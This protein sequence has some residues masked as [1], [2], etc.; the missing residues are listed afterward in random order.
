M[1]PFSDFYSLKVAYGICKAGYL[2]EKVSL[3]DTLMDEARQAGRDSRA[4]L[5][6][7]ISF[8]IGVDDTPIVRTRKTY[9]EVMEALDRRIYGMKEIKERIA[10][11]ILA[12]QYAGVN[13][14]AM[15]LVG[16][17]GVGKTSIA[18][19]VAEV[20]ECEVTYVDCSGVDAVGM[21]GLTKSYC[22]AQPS[23]I[24][25]ALQE[26]GRLDTVL[27]IDELDKLSTGDGHGDPFSALIKPLGFQKAFHDEFFDEDI[28]M[29]NTKIIVTANDIDKIPGYIVNRSE[30]HTSE[31]QSRI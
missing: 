18:E 27:L 2:P 4:D 17:P 26:T 11:H 13:N 7:Q 24:T 19:A 23:K 28:D 30:E 10:E 29:S 12:M 22:G 16:S 6:K 14:L 8:M 3:I 9:P 15:L 31:L 20:Y 21:C 5:I 1:T 25:D